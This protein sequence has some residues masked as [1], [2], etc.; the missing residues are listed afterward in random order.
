MARGDYVDKHTLFRDLCVHKP[1]T[2]RS[3][4]KGLQND[5]QV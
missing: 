5:N 2:K 4:M 3:D 1:C